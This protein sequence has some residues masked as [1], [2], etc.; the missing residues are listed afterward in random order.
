MIVKQVLVLDFFHIKVVDIW[1]ECQLTVFGE[2]LGVSHV[3]Q[4]HLAAGEEQLLT[5]DE[6]SR[7][8]ARTAAGDSL[9]VL[10]DLRLEG[11]LGR[12]LGLSLLVKFLPHF[13]DPARLFRL[14]LLRS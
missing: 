4:L 12:E 8:A 10:A 6:S 7:V 14:D 3:F 5:L 2:E 1:R 11:Q 13:V 9:R